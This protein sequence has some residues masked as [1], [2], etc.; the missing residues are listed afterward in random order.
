[1]SNCTLFELIHHDLT[2]WSSKFP[3]KFLFIL[4]FFLF[5]GIY[6]WR[7]LSLALILNL[8]G[9]L[10]Y[11]LFEDSCCK[12]WIKVIPVYPI[13]VSIYDLPNI[14][15]CRALILNYLEVNKHL[16]NQLQLKF[17]HISACI[18]LK[19][20][21]FYNCQH[22]S[23]W[24]IWIGNGVQLSFLGSRMILDVLNINLCWIGSFGF[25]SWWSG[26][27]GASN[28]C[29]FI[30]VLFRSLIQLY[31]P[32]LFYFYVLFPLNY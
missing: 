11:S 24:Y 16:S 32:L 1:M 22:F 30:D 5:L 15:D 27:N 19:P 2:L 10:N 25:F 20:L 9:F 3:K 7:L 17:N 23:D 28:I 21:L 14:F 12:K 8:L 26:W 6:R 4:N 31:L 18:Y 29:L 13:L